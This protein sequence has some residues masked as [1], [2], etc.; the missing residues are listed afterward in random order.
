[1]HRLFGGSVDDTLIGPHNNPRTPL[2]SPRTWSRGDTEKN[3]SNN[4]WLIKIHVHPRVDYDWSRYFQLAVVNISCFTN[5]IKSLP[6]GSVTK[7]KKNS[8]LSFLLTNITNLCVS[9]GTDNN[10]YRSK[11]P[12]PSVKF[13]VFRYSR[14]TCGDT[15]RRFGITTLNSCSGNQKIPFP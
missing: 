8:N 13:L 4:E 10:C 3:D 2:P 6:V 5:F 15:T 11:K 9:P 1:M 12:M 7:P 14:V